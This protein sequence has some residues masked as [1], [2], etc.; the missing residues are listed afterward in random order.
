[1]ERSLCVAKHVREQS[2]HATS[3]IVHQQVNR[4]YGPSAKLSLAY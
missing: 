1:M 4:I 3:V 2:L